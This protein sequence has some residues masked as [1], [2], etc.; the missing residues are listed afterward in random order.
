VVSFGLSSQLKKRNESFLYTLLDHKEEDYVMS[1][2]P[3]RLPQERRVRRYR[4]FSKEFK[5]QFS[6]WIFSAPALV[7]LI[8]FMI[9]P[10]VMAFGFAFT[11]QRLLNYPPAQFVWLTN[12]TRLLSEKVFH[13]AIMN[14]F[15]FAAIVVPLQCALALMMAMLINQKIKAIG[16]FRTIYYMPFVTAIVVM[17]YI[18][19]FFYQKD[20]IINVF[21]QAI[22]FGHF[23]AHQWLIETGLAMPAI[24]I[25][26]IWQGAGLQMVLFW[27]GLQEVPEELYEAA[28]LDGA[29]PWMCFLNVTLPQLRN[30]IIVA[31]TMTTTLSFRLF[32]Q[33]QIM[34]QGGPDKATVTS[35]YQIV[36]E[37][38][39]GQ[40]IGYAS[41]M[42][43]VFF[44]IV[45]LFSLLRYVFA[46][47]R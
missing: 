42:T 4:I 5:E 37:G 11:D 25:V 30:A 6:A 20:G 47:E 12:F 29:G 28:R 23:G 32:A 46:R 21:L 40:N 8:A 43:V 36:Q 33:V 38:F 24:I 16:V 39:Q 10:F 15:L 34:T 9:I 26:S 18:W 14:N 45:L 35:V 2:L 44:L 17:A 41:A 13:R 27:A 7:L 19:Q 3:H 31:A 22:T 1:A